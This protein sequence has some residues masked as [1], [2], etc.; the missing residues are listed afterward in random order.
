MRYSVRSHIRGSNSRP[1]RSNYISVVRLL[2]RAVPWRWVC[3]LLVLIPAALSAQEPFQGFGL[4]PN[5]HQRVKTAVESHDYAAAEKLLAEEAERY[6]QSQAVLLALANIL[7]LDGKH[8]N[9]AVALKKA[10]KLGPLDERHQMLLALSYMTIGRLNWARP[11][12]QKLAR[13]NPSNAVYPYWLA[14]IAYKKMEIS[15]A[16]EHAQKAVQLDPSL[17][18]AYDQL[19]L[20]HEAAGEMDRAIAAFEHAIRLNAQSPKKSPWPSLN[21]GNLLFRLQRFE[22]A[23]TRLRESVNIDQ[24]FPVARYR[25]ARVLE[26]QER[27]AEAIAELEEAARLDPTYPEPHYALARIYRRTNDVK[28]AQELRTFQAL[29]KADKQK[30]ISRP[31]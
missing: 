7:F 17:M 24:R 20:S 8:L 26:R 31:D 23:E 25:L 6:P 28:A 29:R 21:L 18:K 4:D 1:L 16:I 30:N 10:E 9:C 27:M 12:F 5:T 14:R 15:L 22:E 2:T 13:L 19:G 3:V 11:E